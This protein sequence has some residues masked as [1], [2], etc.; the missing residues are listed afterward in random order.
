MNRSTTNLAGNPKLAEYL[1]GTRAAAGLSQG[2]IAEA[3]GYSTSQFIS[4]WERG[5]SA[6]PVT[7]LKKLGAVLKADPDHLFNL[8]VEADYEKTKEKLTRVYNDSTL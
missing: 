4:N 3:L 5:I 1:K 7:A 8:V 6:P 2:Q